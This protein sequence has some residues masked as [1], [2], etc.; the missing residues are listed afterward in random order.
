ML[1][2]QPDDKNDINDDLGDYFEIIVRHLEY[3]VKHSL[4][5]FVLEDDHDVIR[6]FREGKKMDITPVI[7]RINIIAL[8]TTLT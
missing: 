8:C 1:V 7:S 4:E 5:A 6:V 2:W 3:K